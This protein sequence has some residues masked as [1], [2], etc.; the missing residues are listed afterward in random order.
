MIFDQLSQL[1][2]YAPI[3]PMI[4]Q[5]YSFLREG[6]HE[7]LEKGTHWIVPEKLRVIREVSQG[8]GLQREILEVHRQHIDIQIVLNGS[9][10]IG[11]RSL[12]EC[13]LPQA[14]FDS[15]RD[16]QFFNDTPLTWLDLH[17]GYFCLFFPQDAHAPLA[18][19]GSVEKL[20]FKLII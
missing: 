2:F 3:H 19:E 5:V 12:H 4:S 17:P 10:R 15:S 9:D 14:E 18:L 1:N 13:K 6:G 8:K 20:I 11:Y 7:R 16:I